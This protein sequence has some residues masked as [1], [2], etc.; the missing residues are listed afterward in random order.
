LQEKKKKRV[1]QEMER[2]GE[3]RSSVLSSSTP[4]SEV[5]KC[6]EEKKLLGVFYEGGQATGVGSRTGGKWET[7]G[8][9]EAFS[10]RTTKKKTGKWKKN[11]QD[12]GMT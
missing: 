4:G 3:K 11:S 6:I 1:M 5:K 9:R 7:K 12:T 8:G 10:G 2:G